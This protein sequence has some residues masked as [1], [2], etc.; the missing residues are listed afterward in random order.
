MNHQTEASAKH[1][2]LQTCYLLSNQGWRSVDT[3]RELGPAV[4]PV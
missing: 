3:G 1:F 2:P 4:V